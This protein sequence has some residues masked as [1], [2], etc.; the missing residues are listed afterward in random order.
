MP[1]LKAV[2]EARY[3]EMFTSRGTNLSYVPV[4]FGLRR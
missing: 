4:T 3:N 1:P 2:A